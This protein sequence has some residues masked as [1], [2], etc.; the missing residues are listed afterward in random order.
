MRLVKLCGTT[1]MIAGILGLAY[2]SQ[3][4]F[5]PSAIVDDMPP[6]TIQQLDAVDAPQHPSWTYY[7]ERVGE[8]LLFP[9]LPWGRMCTDEGALKMA[10]HLINDQYPSA[11][12]LGPLMNQLKQ[13]DDQRT[14]GT[15]Q[16]LQNAQNSL[17]MYRKLEAAQPRKDWEDEISQLEARIVTLK[18]KIESEKHRAPDANVS[19]PDN[20]VVIS[21][22]AFP[23]RYG[24]DIDQVVCQIRFR[25]TGPGWETINAIQGN[26]LK[27]AIYTVQPGKKGWIVNLISVDQ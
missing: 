1:V 9:I 2:V 27:V 13:L 7:V 8:A 25:I 14:G 11:A 17:E 12:R 19:L 20:E 21:G 15:P 23:V 22:E 24:R 3:S 26:A 16:L 18:E 10:K 5:R 6:A 4:G